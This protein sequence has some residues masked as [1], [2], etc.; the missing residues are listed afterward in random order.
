MLKTSSR[1][2]MKTRP[3]SK[4]LNSS[5]PRVFCCETNDMGAHTFELAGG[6]PIL[7]E[8][9]GDPHSYGSGVGSPFFQI[10]VAQIATI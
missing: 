3:S 6:I 8:V 7:L 5:M 9:V 10:K 4:G 2:K 1:E